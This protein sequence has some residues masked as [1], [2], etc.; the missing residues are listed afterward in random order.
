MIRICATLDTSIPFRGTASQ[1]KNILEFAVTRSGAAL[2][3]HEGPSRWGWGYRTIAGPNPSERRLTSLSWGTS[4][5]DMEKALSLITPHVLSESAANAGLPLG[6]LNF[7]QALLPDFSYPIIV[8]P[9]TPIRVLESVRSGRRKAILQM[10]DH[11]VDGLNRTMSYRFQRP[12]AL[13]M[14]QDVDMS[15]SFG[16]TVKAQVIENKAS[17]QIVGLPGIIQPFIL[18]GPPDDLAAVWFSGCGSGTGSGFGWI[19]DGLSTLS[20]TPA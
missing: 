14:S 4:D 9:V 1:L 20:T 17:H 5:P 16:N 3:S 7:K 12:F 13:K 8:K 18:D 19:D 15:L 6:V 11:W 10:D 2:R